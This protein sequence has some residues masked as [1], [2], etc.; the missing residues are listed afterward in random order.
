VKAGTSV[1][2]KNASG[3]IIATTQ[4]GTGYSADFRSGDCL[5]TWQATNA[6]DSN[7]YTITISHRGDVTYNRAEL[8]RNGWVAA[9][10]LNAP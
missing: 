10:T 3:T 6:P 9:S 1:V 2:V 5:F 7:F 8:A 4:L